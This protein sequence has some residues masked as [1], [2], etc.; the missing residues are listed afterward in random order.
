MKLNHLV[1]SRRWVDF[2]ESTAMG[3]Q[4]NLAL[5][6]LTEPAIGLQAPGVCPDCNR[7]YPRLTVEDLAAVKTFH[8][9]SPHQNEEGH[10]FVTRNS[11]PFFSLP[12]Q[13]GLFLIARE[14][15]CKTA[16]GLL[17]LSQRAKVAQKLLSAFLD[18]LS[19]GI[20]GSHAALEFSALRQINQILLSLFRG[21]SGASRRAFDLILS[22]LIIMLDA[23]ASW[24]EYRD[25]TGE[26]RIFKGEPAAIASHLRMKVP[27]EI[28]QIEVEGAYTKGSLS[29]LRPG[30]PKLAA[31]LLPLMAQECSIVF[32]VEHL[33]RLMQS[34]LSRL[35]GALNSAVFLV[36]EHMQIAYLN[37][38]AEALLHQS[39]FSLIGISIG[40]LPQF[41]ADRIS[42][43]VD[44]PI[45]DYKTTFHRNTD[46]ILLD[47]Q[48][49]PLRDDTLVA[50][51]LIIADDR[52]DAYHWQEIGRQAESFTT[53]ASVISPLAHELRN[54][55]AA[56]KGL[57]QL[58]QRHNDPDKVSGYINL[59]LR[60]I[61]RMSILVNEFLQI[62]RSTG[63]HFE[64][65]TLSS[66]VEDLLP[67]VEGESAAGAVEI[68]CNLEPVPSVRAD[69]GQLIQVLLNL[70]HNAV[71][72]AGPEGRVEI[73]LKSQ[74][75]WIVLEVSDN[76]PG[77]EAEVF[78]KLFQPFVT[79]KE[80]GTGLGLAISKAIITNH[81]G[82]I[83]AA[84]L[85]VRG[86]VFSIKLP[87][88]R[89]PNEAPRPIDVLLA[90]R[91]EMI[92]YPTEQVLHAAGFTVN[93]PKSIDQLSDLADRCR[94]TILILD[95]AAT[96][97]QLLEIRHFW[98]EAKILIIGEPK[99]PGNSPEIRILPKPLN[100]GRLIELVRSMVGINPPSLT[101]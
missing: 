59:I 18:T 3:L 97:K 28:L 86:A 54:P 6:S 1:N 99:S 81:F 96:A 72:A 31:S 9:R 66:L 13:D 73:D 46:S 49:L 75:D 52:T 60:E 68:R 48:I 45:R 80:R 39:A 56:A 92:A 70:I 83:S 17:S 61:D 35:L 79:T 24:L 94:P 38:A 19:E 87:V 98:P 85:P 11:E 65:V 50:G 76:G 43:Q 32:E 33:F 62:G 69:P 4:L 12:V 5:R 14:C 57:L 63:G 16:T 41:W 29:L 77:I 21:E 42:N 37:P 40:V 91:D 93:I 74:G 67:L 20:A 30:D 26:Q 47:W 55:L 7:V 34:Q 101:H 53:V 44:E 25:E 2:L 78:G 71:E 22:A 84:N 27:G 8:P 58:V 10:E 82:K 90:V 15:P 88:E 51:W 89:E 100:Y 64:S 36:N 95:S 23:D